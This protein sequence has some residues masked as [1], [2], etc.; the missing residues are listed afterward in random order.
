MHRAIKTVTKLQA[1]GGT[2]KNSPIILN[3]KFLPS[4]RASSFTDP[5]PPRFECSVLYQGKPEIGLF[6][7]GA[8]KATGH[9]PKVIFRSFLG[10]LLDV[11]PQG[12]FLLDVKV[13][14]FVA[15][16]TACCYMRS[17]NPDA[18][19]NGLL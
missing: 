4:K 2:V 3:T 9:G 15:R 8:S 13:V 19:A 10:T 12:N 17:A 6:L 7:E 14:G 5:P 1:A 18:M 11:R 16:T